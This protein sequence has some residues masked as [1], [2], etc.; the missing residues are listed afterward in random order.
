MV[1]GVRPE[2]L[3]SGVP[4][5]AVSELKGVNSV[6]STQVPASDES[7]AS[8]LTL[9]TFM[10]SCW[11]AVT[12][13]AG[14]VLKVV[15]GIIRW[16]WNCMSAPFRSEV[17][18]SKVHDLLELVG[19]FLLIK[20]KTQANSEMESVHTQIRTAYNK[21]DPLIKQA[22]QTRILE[23][24]SSGDT[25][26]K[27]E[28]G[29]V[30]IIDAASYLNMPNLITE[31]AQ[32]IPSLQLEAIEEK[33]AKAITDE[34]RVEL[35]LQALQIELSAADPQMTNAVLNARMFAIFNGFENSLK[36]TI[37]VQIRMDFSR[38]DYSNKGV[39]D[40]DGINVSITDDQ[41]PLLAFKNDSR[42]FRITGAL[43][44]VRDSLKGSN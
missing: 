17:G 14:A 16:I 10:T 28:D 36:E 30:D 41:F 32:H 24:R 26:G 25:F 11:N 1:T 33:L 8:E 44:R 21:L 37:S 12:D 19:L 5:E 23:C 9:L 6:L 7:D 42:D 38:S 27:N 43:S 3:P 15:S 4:I 39:I 35:L 34:T 40:L 22:L 18:V 2:S 31:I 29:T 20:D 13:A